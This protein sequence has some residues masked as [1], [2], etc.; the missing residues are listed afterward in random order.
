MSYR[1]L[2][3]AEADLELIGDYIAQ[4]SPV[5]ARRFIDRLTLK[6]ASLARNSNIGRSR[7][8]IRP[9]LRSFPYGAYIILYRAT[10]TGVDIVRV[11]HAARNIDD[12]L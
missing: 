11:V 3:E 12:L 8:D 4:D 9:E 6:F 5:N 10:A 1:L 2:P 7:P